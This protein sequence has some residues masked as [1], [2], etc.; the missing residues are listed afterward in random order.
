[1]NL[2][3][4]DREALLALYWSSGGPNWKHNQGWAD[5]DKDLSSWHGVTL[6]KHGKVLKLHLDRN[7]LEGESDARI[8]YFY[9][10]ERVSQKFAA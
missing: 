5:N 3:R 1:M 7:Q 8:I 9:P 10:Y 2:Q 4:D 6:D